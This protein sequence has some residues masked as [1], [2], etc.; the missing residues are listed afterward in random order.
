MIACSS[1]CSDEP[2]GGRD[3]GDGL[4][5]QT[6]AQ[7]IVRNLLRIDVLTNAHI[8]AKGRHGKADAQRLTRQKLWPSAQPQQIA[9]L[10]AW[11]GR[12]VGAGVDAMDLAL[13]QIEATRR[14]IPT[15]ISSTPVS[16]RAARRWRA[17]ARPVAEVRA[18]PGGLS[19]LS[20]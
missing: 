2:C 14:L 13:A 15:T 1:L 9:Q 5:P 6:A 19:E 18:D 10:G 20:R 16:P 8:G 17:R 11:R 7:R 4:V 12:C 3:D